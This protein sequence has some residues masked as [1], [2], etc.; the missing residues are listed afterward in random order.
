MCG[1]SLL[2]NRIASPLPECHFGS[3]SAKKIHGVGASGTATEV[4]RKC[5]RPTSKHR[6]ENFVEGCFWW[7]YHTRK[8]F[9]K[10]LCRRS[11]NVTIPNLYHIM[12]SRI[13]FVCIFRVLGG[14]F[15]FPNCTM[16][17]NNL[18]ACMLASLCEARFWF[19]LCS[20]FHRIDRQWGSL[21]PRQW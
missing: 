11:Y 3:L 14:C 8:D 9:S 19:L 16:W 2:N 20:S 21:H 7:F 4:P 13:K 1:N 12:H 18:S 17:L 10:W 6:Y 15:W 5:Q